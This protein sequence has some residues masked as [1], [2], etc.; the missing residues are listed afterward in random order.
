MPEVNSEVVGVMLNTEVRV[1]INT[2]VD[3]VEVVASM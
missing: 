3:A 1:M 2:E